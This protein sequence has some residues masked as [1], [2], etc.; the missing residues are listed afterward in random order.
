MQSQIHVWLFSLLIGLSSGFQPVSTKRISYSSTKLYGNAVDVDNDIDHNFIN[1]REHSRR[2]ALLRLTT[3]FAIGG[4]ILTAAPSSSNAAADLFK[5]VKAL[6]NANN[7]GMIGKPINI[8]NSNGDPEKQ[9]PQV[10]ISADQTIEVSAPP[11]IMTAKDYVQF[12]WLKDTK[13]NEVVLVKAFPK[14]EDG[15]KNTNR[16]LVAKVPK[17]VVLQPY[18][19]WTEYGLWKGKPFQ[20]D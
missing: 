15:D 17:G 7:I 19:F 14:P 16:S 9:L 8:P 1:P 6:E 20:V 5:Q 2:S 10:K 4:G 12:I 18:L 11:H 13:S 3:T